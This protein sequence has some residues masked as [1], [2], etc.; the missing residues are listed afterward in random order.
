MRCDAAA[1]REV[2]IDAGAHCFAEG[3]YL[4]PLGEIAARAGVER[5]TLY[6]NFRD[7]LSWRPSSSAMSKHSPRGPMPAV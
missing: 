5:G 3:G 1:R 4:V 7:R 2:L 6:R